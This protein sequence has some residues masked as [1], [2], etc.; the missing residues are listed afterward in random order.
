M[1]QPD[2]SDADRCQEIIQ[3]I[4]DN[5]GEQTFVIG[6]TS[7]PVSRCLIAL[8]V[9]G[10]IQNVPDDQPLARTYRLIEGEQ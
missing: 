2:L 10:I 9:E 1:N 6:Q 4:R 5:G 8:V 3:A 7:V